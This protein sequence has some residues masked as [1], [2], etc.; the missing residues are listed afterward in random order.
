MARIDEEFP[1]R[2][3]ELPAS[4][5]FSLPREETEFRPPAPEAEYSPPP[6][7]DY[8]NPDPS[9][10]FTPP[11]G[12]R[13]ESSPPQRRR[14]V[15]RRL[16]YAA[17]AIVL[18]TAAFT[19]TPVSIVPPPL[20]PAVLAAPS[21]APAP[22]DEATP[23][24]TPETVPTPEP[25]PVSKTPEITTDFFCFSHEH[26]A[27]LH[28]SNTGALHSVEVTVR[29]KVLD[30]QVYDH[31]LSEEEIGTGLFELPMLS[32]GD[33]YMENMKA[34]DAAHGWP[35]FE[36]TVNAWYE[37]ETG[38]GEDMLT[39]TAEPNF[40]LG[41]GLSYISPSWDWYD[42]P[43]SF[44]ITPWEETEE[45]R[46]VIDDPSAVKNPLTFSV[47]ISCNGRHAKPEEYEEHIRTDE[48]DIRNSET[49][50]LTPHIGYT[51]ELVLR[52]P[53][54]MPEEG[55][56]HIT[57]HQYLASTGEIWVR[58]IDLDYPTHYDR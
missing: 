53:D 19:E 33:V 48:Y 6:G 57:I 51:K 58:E 15:L 23:A 42:T 2:E 8:E 38:D 9:L 1:I 44:V 34:Y 24:P 3:N 16:V 37:N 31:F 21:A 13:A 12:G 5:E 22:S 27:R 56:I 36:M 52:R 11:G 32:T 25:T 49:G 28:M 54:W 41:V 18:I 43:D 45:I 29:E 39:L 47:D 50:E 30:K 35:E 55:T 10:E 40:E 46:Y 17:A 20:S 7:T 14:R 4:D 26:H